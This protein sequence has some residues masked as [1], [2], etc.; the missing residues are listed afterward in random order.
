MEECGRNCVQRKFMK[1]HSNTVFIPKRTNETIYIAFPPNWIYIVVRPTVSALNIVIKRSL[2]WFMNK[3]KIVNWCVIFPPDDHTLYC[4]MQ[5]CLHL[6]I[7]RVYRVNG[8]DFS[9]FCFISMPCFHQKSLNPPE[10]GPFSG[11]RTF[12]AHPGIRHQYLHLSM[13][14]PGSLGPVHGILLNFPLDGWQ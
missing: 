8:Y 3:L 12:E 10:R 11:T 9:L 6:A 2:T 7:L 13:R 4:W 14:H 1:I 5:Y